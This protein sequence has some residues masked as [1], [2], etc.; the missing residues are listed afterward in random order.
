MNKKLA[1]IAEGIEELKK[2]N[3]LIVKDNEHRENQADIIFP[4]ETVS[5][6]KINFL[7]KE[8]RGLVCVPLTSQK[9]VSLNLPLML[10]PEENEEKLSCNFTQ[11][12]DAAN[13]TSY[14][15]SAS[16]RTL[17]VRTILNPRAKPE[18]ILKPGHVFPL[19]AKEGGVI[20]R[21][22]HTEA[23]VELSVLSGYLPVGVLCE[24]LQDNGEVAKNENLENF[25]KKFS[26]KSISIDDLI[27][28]RKKYPLKTLSLKSQL[29]H[30]AMAKLPTEY[31]LFEI[32]IYKTILDSKE[33]IALTMGNLESPEPILVRIHSQ[34]VTG[35]TLHSLRCDCG[36][37]LQKSLQIISKNKRGVLIY[38]NQEGRGIGLTNKIKAYDLQE[39]GLDTVEANHQLGFPADI[40]SYKIAAEILEDL[41]ISKI[42]LLT[43]NPDKIKELKKYGIKNIERIDIE[44]LPIKYNR[45]YLLTKKNKLG[46][47][48]T[49]V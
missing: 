6:E 7:I 17:T 41:N 27:T 46:H 13:V 49:K 33:H 11:S 4:A 38:L 19:L 10:P 39:K 26:L 9:A 48:L 35:D 3:M 45:K 42:K 20:E 31:G 8:C 12:V 40:R 47:L 24:I 25:A 30:S 2:G 15:I 14:G 1:S 22:G 5:N 18:D 29:K 28:Y 32:R 37:Q 21:N 16:D 23:A 44:S 34:C 43:N 36:E